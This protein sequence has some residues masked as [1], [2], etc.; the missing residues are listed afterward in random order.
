MTAPLWQRGVWGDL[1]G[2]RAKSPSVPLFQKGD[3][4]GRH[5][6]FLKGKPFYC[7]W[8]CREVRSRWLANLSP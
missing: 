7:S 3:A 4:T 1:E 6:L 2:N 5:P 8:Q